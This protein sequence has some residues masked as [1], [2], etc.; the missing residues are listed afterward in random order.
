L[1]AIVVGTGPG[2]FTGLRVAAAFA[3][4]LARGSAAALKG[5]SHAQAACWALLADGEEGLWAHDLRSGGVA[6][7][8]CARSAAGLAVLEPARALPLDAARG[9]CAGAGVL[10]GDPEARI[11]L[12]ADALD[13]RWRDS[14][15]AS[16]EL[17]LLE[18]GLRALERD[19]PD[20]ASALEPLYLRPF[21][22]PS[23]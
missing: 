22:A 9:L 10:I 17:A 2:S 7:A 13:P 5:L 14:S 23:S 3:Q 19:G 12:G 18:L 20:A 15:R 8:R 1:R 21:G 16:V 11:A 6:L 4:G